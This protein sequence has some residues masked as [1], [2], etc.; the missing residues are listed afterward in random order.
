MNSLI[1]SIIETDLTKKSF[2]TNQKIYL[3]WM[4]NK[5]K[6]ERNIY[7]LSRLFD[8]VNSNEMAFCITCYFYDYFI[9]F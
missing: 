2:K 1:F 8:P 7:F 6:L 5:L 9:I 4:Y 3:I